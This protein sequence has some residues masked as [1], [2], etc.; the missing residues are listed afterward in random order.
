MPS[1]TPS[2]PHDPTADAKTHQD[3]T[4]STHES[5]STADEFADVMATQQFATI[6]D[7]MKSPAIIDL[8][9][10]ERAETE[11]PAV[12]DDAASL[13]ART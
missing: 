13:P 11:A 10:A 5:Q 6:H 8:V 12:A 2:A 1:A 4:M 9:A 3:P 7:L